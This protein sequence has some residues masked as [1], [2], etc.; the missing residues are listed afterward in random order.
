M[1]S[2][3][4]RLQFLQ[5]HADTESN[6]GPAHSAAAVHENRLNRMVIDFALRNEMW[7]TATQLSHVHG[8]SVRRYL[9]SRIEVYRAHFVL[10]PGLCR[11]GTVHIESE[12]DN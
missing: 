7:D 6:G 11:G 5:R 4:K 9:N 8:L 3:G 12:K 2:L 1:D 10:F